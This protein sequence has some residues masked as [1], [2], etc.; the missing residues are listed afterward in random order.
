MLEASDAVFP[1]TL[2]GKHRENRE[3]RRIVKIVMVLYPG[4][5]HRVEYGDWEGQPVPAA[6]KESFGL[7]EWIGD[8]GH[9][10]VETFLEAAG[11]VVE[12]E[13]DRTCSAS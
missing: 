13:R 12:P 3:G 4:E 11:V 2:P 6:T 7:R 1:V 8:Q 5:G 10:L 9:E